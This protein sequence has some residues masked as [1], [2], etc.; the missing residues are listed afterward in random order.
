MSTSVTRKARV[1]NALRTLRDSV[2]TA[3]TRA[4]IRDD[5]LSIGLVMAASRECCVRHTLILCFVKIKVRSQFGVFRSRRVK[6]LRWT[7]HTIG[8]Q[9]DL[10]NPPLGD[11]CHA[12]FRKRLSRSRLLARLQRFETA[13]LAVTAVEAET[14][15]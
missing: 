11:G 12:R 9:G 14:R 10:R 1:W 5:D 15:Q 8:L 7:Y 3:P 4:V 13:E 2:A 6:R